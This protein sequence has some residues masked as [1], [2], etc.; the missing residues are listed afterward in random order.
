MHGRDP[1]MAID[2]CSRLRFQFKWLTSLLFALFLLAGAGTANAG[3]MYN[4]VDQ[5]TGDI[6]AQLT[7]VK[8]PAESESDFELL[9]FTSVGE[10]FFNGGDSIEEF[11]DFQPYIDSRPNCTGPHHQRRPRSTWDGTWIESEYWHGGVG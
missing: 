6:L 1:L 8:V 5:K 9:R 3:V 10:A 11:T 7:L 4:F 2:K